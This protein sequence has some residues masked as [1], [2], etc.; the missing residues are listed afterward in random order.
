MS[1]FKQTLNELYLTGYI[2]DHAAANTF[3]K[4]YDNAT[5]EKQAAY[6]KHALLII[7]KIDS[8]NQNQLDNIESIKKN[9]QF[10]SW[11]FIISI[12]AAV[13]YV[14]VLAVT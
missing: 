3:A 9:L 6:N 7:E 10:I 4:R 1:N 12:F 11:L 2:E 8:H 13:I 5:A 14:F